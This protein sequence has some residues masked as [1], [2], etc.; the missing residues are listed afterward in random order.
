MHSASEDLE[1]FATWSCAIAHLF[2]TQI[3]ASFAGIGAGIGYQKLV[4]ELLGIEVAKAETRSDWLRRPLSAEQL[5]YAT[6]A[7]WYFENGQKEPTLP[8]IVRMIRWLA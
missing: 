8:V 4:R 6:S 3:A 7:L 5:D 2:D 1:A